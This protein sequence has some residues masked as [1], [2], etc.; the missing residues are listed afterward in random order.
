MRHCEYIVLYFKVIKSYIKVQ[1]MLYCLLIKINDDK[2]IFQSKQNAN[3]QILI[4]FSDT[5]FSITIFAFEYNV[6]IS[7]QC[8][9]E[10]PSR[11]DGNFGDVFVIKVTDST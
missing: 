1:Q 2:K 6:I 7:C 10:F 5:Q 8:G 3:L 11:F 9:T 4:S